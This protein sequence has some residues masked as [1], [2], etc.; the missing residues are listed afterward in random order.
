M[1]PRFQDLV[2]VTKELRKLIVIERL[3]LFVYVAVIV[4]LMVYTI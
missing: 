4:F 2:T 3:Y 1:N